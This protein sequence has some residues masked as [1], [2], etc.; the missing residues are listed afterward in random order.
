MTTTTEVLKNV[1]K[2]ERKLTLDEV[3]LISEMRKVLFEVLFEVFSV[4]ILWVF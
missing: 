1:K 4:E 3:S 2:K